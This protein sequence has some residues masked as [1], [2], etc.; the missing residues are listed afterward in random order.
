MR[1]AFRE[2]PWSLENN[3]SS[4]A[5]RAAIEL[6][7]LIIGQQTDLESVRQLAVKI[8]ALV[9]GDAGG[10]SVP[11]PS[12]VVVMNRAIHDC[13]WSSEPPAR[14]DDLVRQAGQIT[15]RLTRLAQGNPQDE[16]HT[17]IDPAKLRLFCLTLS[18]LAVGAKV[19]A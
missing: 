19:L 11:N 7:N 3:L 5:C 8:T 16:T 10:Q 15:D 1:D 6:D 17:D 12:A 14:V 13:H 2:G 18:R 9:S 4:I